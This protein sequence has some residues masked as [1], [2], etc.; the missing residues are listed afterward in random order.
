V[1]HG[2]QQIG[3]DLPIVAGNGNIIYAEM[4]QFGAFLP[5]TVLFAGVQSF[6]DPRDIKGPLKDAI[7]TYLKALAPTKPDLGQ[8]LAYDPAMIV[9]DTLRKLPPNANAQQLRDAILAIHGYVGSAGVYDFH[10]GDN[11]G[12][13]EGNVVLVRYDAGRDLFVPVSKPGGDPLP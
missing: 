11:R 6:R 3:L 13:G 4:R 10:S 8:S 12:L 2:I 9:V 7:A 1:L 5:K